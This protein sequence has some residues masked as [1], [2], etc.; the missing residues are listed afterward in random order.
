MDSDWE[1]YEGQSF[2]W[3][4]RS[5][6]QEESSSVPSGSAQGSSVATS[7]SAMPD[8]FSSMLKDTTA[9]HRAHL[10]DLNCKIC[11]GNV[12]FFVCL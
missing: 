4:I 10:F 9:E 2:N 8:I 11:T 3:F 12:I 6:E 7:G 5:Q 1:S